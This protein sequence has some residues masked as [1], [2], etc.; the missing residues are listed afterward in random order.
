VCRLRKSFAGGF[1][2]HRIFDIF[3]NYVFIFQLKNTRPR[4]PNTSKTSTSSLS[5]GMSSMELLTVDDNDNVSSSI[6]ANEINVDTNANEQRATS[7]NPTDDDERVN[8]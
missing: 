6:S 2:L 5:A 4:R 1:Q 8:I 3:N 7:E